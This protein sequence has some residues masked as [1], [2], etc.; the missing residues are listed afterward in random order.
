MRSSQ[1]RIAATANSAVSDVMP[2]VD[3]AGGTIGKVEE[4]PC[5]SVD[6]VRTAGC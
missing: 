2:K 4:V 1:Q 6:G 3:E 5:R